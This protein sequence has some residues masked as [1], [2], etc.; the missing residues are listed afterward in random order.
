MAYATAAGYANLP[1]G[2]FVPVIYSQKVLKY[3]RRS[4]VAEAITN[5]DYSGEIENFGDTVNIIKEPTISVSSYT[6][7]STVNT[8]DLADD[9]IQLVVDQGNYFAFKVD[10]IEERHS[11]LN[12][13]SLATSSGAYTLKKAFDYNVLNNIYSNA[14]TSA[15]DT[16]TDAS[17]ITGTGTGSACTGNELANA[18]SAAAKVMDENDV[19]YENRWLVADPEFYEVLRQ[20][21]AKLMDSSVTGEA[22]SALMNGL[23]TDRIIHGFKLYQTNAIV[24]GG[25]G[26]AASHTFSST[27]AGEHIF[28]YGHMSDVATASHIAKTEVIRDPDSFAD[29]VRGLHVFGRKVLR[30]SGTGY[31]GVFSGVVDLG[32]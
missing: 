30:G 22:G 16:G 18:V 3:F 19:P 10:D 4:S 14:A 23:V 9:Q 24:N 32:S 29:I 13:E 26:A 11:H 17:P 8:Q 20:A 6:R 21:D 2:N 5:T 1:S 7:G 25:D 28:L 15:G 31:K 12:F 27:N